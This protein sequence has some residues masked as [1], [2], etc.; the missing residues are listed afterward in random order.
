MKIS[1]EKLFEMEPLRATAFILLKI[2]CEGKKTGTNST[3]KFWHYARTSL[4]G[5]NSWGCYGPTV[6]EAE[7]KANADIM[8]ENLKSHGWHYLV[9][10]IR[11][12]LVHRNWS[13]FRK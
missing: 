1:T 12:D 9:V 6:T 10:D 4:M 13:G 7:V 3:T 2:S 8:A 5:W 11:W